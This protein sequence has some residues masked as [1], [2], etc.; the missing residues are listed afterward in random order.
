[1]KKLRNPLIMMLAGLALMAVT[2]WQTKH[3]RF[4]A[5]GSSANSHTAALVSS[6]PGGGAEDRVI[7]EGRVAAYHGAQV[8]L[9]TEIVGRIERLP[10]DEKA[11]VAKGDLIAEVKADDLKAALMEA[12]ARLAEIDAEIKLAEFEL[13]RHRKLWEGR[14]VSQQE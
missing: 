3:L 9:S 13:T 14:A 12:N 5:S 11:L 7:A 4:Q 6:P 8:T 1:M 10:I 2:A